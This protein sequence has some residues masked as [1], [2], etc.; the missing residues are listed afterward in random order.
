MEL[1]KLFAT[2][3]IRNNEANNAIDDTTN[4]AEK[5]KSK[6]SSAF[7]KIGKSVV[8]GLRSEH[9]KKFSQ[10]LDELTSTVNK[11]NDKLQTL[12]NKYKDLYLTYGENS[13]EAKECAKEIKSLSAELKEN[14]IK[15]S[16]AD[17][18]VDKFDQSLEDA[19]E[20]AEKTENR[21][22]SAFKKIGAAVISYFAVDKIKDFGLECINAASDLEATSAQFSQVFGNLESTASTNLTKIADSTGVVENR[23]KGSYTKIAAFAKTTGMDTADAL[24]LA[25]RAMVAIADSAAFYDRTLEETTESL[26]SF[27]KGNYENDAAL[28]LSCTETT[29]NAAANQLY[30]KSFKDL[31]EQQ[32]QLTLLQMVED[33]NKLSGAMG[34]S[35]RETDTWTNQT[36]NLKQ[37]WQDLKANLGTTVLSTVVDVVK[38]LSEKVQNAS[39]KFDEWKP[40]IQETVNKLKDVSNWISQ[41]QGLMIALATVI[42]VITA[43]VTAYNIVQG[44]KTAMDAAEATSLWGL[45]AAK[46]ADAAA[47]MA[48]LAPYLLVAAAIAAL[49]AIIVLLVKNWDKVKEVASNVWDKIKEIWSNV[50]EWFKTNVIDPI[51]NFFQG[52]W[53]KVVEIWE[54]IK[55]AISFAFQLIANIISAAFQIITLPFRFIWE[56]CK[57]YVF[58]VFDAIRE[59]INNAINKIKEII[60]TVLNAI[61]IVWNTVWT[62][63]KD[64]LMP[65]INSIKDFISTAFNAIKN[66]ISTVVN[67]VKTVISTVF[68]A[69]RDVITNIINSV[70]NTVTNVF[71]AIKN[72][73]SVPLNAVK[74]TVSNVFDAIRDKIDSVISKAKDI[75]Q[76]GLDTIKGFFDKLKLK[77]PDLKLP[78]FKV[79]GEFSVNPP[80]VPKFAIDW[81]DK[82]MDDGMIMNEPTIFGVNS[83]GQFMAGGET[84]SETVVGTQSLMN[85]INNAVGQS[86]NSLYDVLDKIL[87]VLKNID[88]SMYDR[89]VAALQTMGIEFDER[90]LARLVK[91]YA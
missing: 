29:R 13:K 39:E 24:G 72:A 80:K 71:N 16:K 47:T 84:G 32:K 69:I 90:E 88:N 27:L 75:V 49:I 60:T 85:M 62:A 89:I 43:A 26:Q 8:E 2:I 1:F 53:D 25:D 42:G 79:D 7:A 61:K 41:H 15:L 67:T 20:S 56:N 36:G 3:A 28:G 74:S 63:V 68:N 17:K 81:Y 52:L 46:I 9:P 54:G 91:K 11:Q 6:I 50:S 31:S 73:I 22:S 10:S 30:G 5:S 66:I 44:V 38:S 51:V 14:E 83:K 35:A 12:K 34:Q 86:N 18:A 87:A 77:F 4:K 58:A 40:K 33:A 55:N 76:K 78:H 37:A 45:V 59:F 19:S 57:E 82:A 64:F 65:I 21:M 48:A 23:M 70:K